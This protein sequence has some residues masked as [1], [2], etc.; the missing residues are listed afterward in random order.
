MKH[1]RV[2]GGEFT[3]VNEYENILDRDGKNNMLTNV[4]VVNMGLERIHVIINNGDELPLDSTET[5]TLGDLT[6][7]SI[8]IVEKDATVRYMGVE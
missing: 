7:D 4:T 3:T 1:R 6:I 5:M 2:K 8:V